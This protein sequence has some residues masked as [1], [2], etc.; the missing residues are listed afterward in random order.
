MLYTG[1]FVLRYYVRFL[2]IRSHINWAVTIAYCNQHCNRVI[3]TDPGNP[4]T[5]R[6]IQ[7]V[8]THF[9]TLNYQKALYYGHLGTNQ[10]YPDYQGVLIFQVILYDKVPFGTSSK[11]VEYAG[12]LIVHN[13]RFHCTII[14]QLKYL[15]QWSG[16]SVRYLK[17]AVYLRI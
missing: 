9:D 5:Q 8:L 3:I 16:T 6:V 4:L 13:N 14:V 7:S 2:Q 11:C 17:P 12:V 10:K 1:D 15:V